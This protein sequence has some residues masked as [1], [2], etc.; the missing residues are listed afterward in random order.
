[1]KIKA[2]PNKPSNTGIEQWLSTKRMGRNQS[3]MLILSV[4]LA[5]LIKIKEISNKPLNTTTRQ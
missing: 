1:M 4:T 5:M 3:D 2:T